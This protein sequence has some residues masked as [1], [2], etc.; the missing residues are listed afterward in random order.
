MQLTHSTSWLGSNQ[1]PIWPRIRVRSHTMSFQQGYSVMATN[2]DGEIDGEADHGLYEHNTRYLSQYVWQINGQRLAPVAAQPVSHNSML[3]Y[4]LAKKSESKPPYSEIPESALDIQIARFIGQGMHEDI[5]LINHAGSMLHVNLSLTLEVD[6]ADM[7]EVQQ[8]SRQQIGLTTMHWNQEAQTLTFHY[9]IADIHH[10]LALK[11]QSNMQGQY[12]QGQLYWDIELAPHQ[13]AQL[14]VLVSPIFCGE[15]LSP[16]QDCYNFSPQSNTREKTR[17]QWLTSATRL[18]TPNV[19]VRR[20]YDMAM[21]DLASMR[22]WEEDQAPNAWVPAAGLPTYLGVFGRDILTAGWQAGVISADMMRGAIAVMNKYQATKTND[23]RDEQP[24][25]MVHEVRVGPLSLLDYIPQHYYY[26]STTSTPLYLV[27]L[28]EFYHWTGDKA[29]LE[30]NREHMEKA[31]H[32]IETYGDLDSDGF[33]EYQTRSTQG[34]KNQGWKDSNE[35]IVYADGRQVETPIATCEEQAW[36]Y[37][38]FVR[39][40]MLYMALKEF[41]QAERLLTKAHKL[42][43]RFNKHFWMP[44]ENFYALA[45]DP[46]KQQVTSITSNPGHC[47]VSGIIDEDK[48]GIT[49]GR[50]LSPDLFSGWGIRTLSSKHPSYNPYSYHLGSVW[51]VE[52]GTFCL[53]FVRYGYHPHANLLAEAIFSASSLFEYGRLPEAISG[54]PRDQAHPFPSVYPQSNMPQAWSS[55][56]IPIIIQAMLGLYPFAPMK[57]LFL[58]PHLPEWLPELSLYKLKIGNAEVSLHFW[59]DSGGATH[60]RVLE[61]KG[62]LRILPHWVNIHTFHQLKDFSE[63]HFIKH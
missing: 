56:A 20:A 38:A 55:S 28:S 50:L 29:L 62:T 6:F 46:Q 26:G 36:V 45:L 24:G 61:K 22:L 4:Y 44:E 49:I 40:A 41:N 57:A 13:Q 10:G 23:W 12:R 60:Y 43:E 7:N 21:T 19:F 15:Q 30:R 2:I 48:A 52:N 42:K 34:L 51:P 39:S 33:Y 9:T 8:Q 25:K 18:E 3:G 5:R 27:V 53:A 47:L 54:H 37:E 32:W 11:V 17:E 14:C 58:D 1:G 63:S 59:R 35:G 31:L 16:T